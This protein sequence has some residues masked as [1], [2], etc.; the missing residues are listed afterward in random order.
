LHQIVQFAI[1]AVATS[2]LMA[3]LWAV[4]RRTGN[5]GIVDV[6]WAGSIGLAAVFFAATGRGD[7]TSR[8]LA[9]V[10]GGVW[11]ARLTW[12]L[13]RRVVGHPEEGRYATLRANWGEKAQRR[14]FEFFQMQAAAAVFFA[15]PLLLLSQR[16]QDTWRWTNWLGIAMWTA[17]VLGVTLADG[18]LARFRQRP[19]NRGKTCRS[20]LWRYS[21]HPNYFFEWLHW[22]AYVPLT[23]DAPAG[24]L[25]VLVPLV[26]LYFLFFVTG[27]PPTEA[28]ALASRGDEYRSYQRTT[29][30]FVPWFPKKESGG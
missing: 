25:A 4:Q 2:S 30:V 9:A 12:Y 7:A 16:T 23:I 27:I 19:E 3:G 6:A 15:L 24:W 26:L 22:C 17:G 13:F 28:Q 14:L 5:A 1:A 18:Q 29:S 11:S 20:G 10:L 21:R 8:W